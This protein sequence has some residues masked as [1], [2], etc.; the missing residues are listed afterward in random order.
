MEQ[1]LCKCSVHAVILVD[2]KEFIPLDSLDDE[3]E[4]RS[5]PDMYRTIRH[6]VQEHVEDFV[7]RPPGVG[8]GDEA[9]KGGRDKAIHPWACLPT[10]TD[11]FPRNKQPPSSKPLLFDFAG[12]S[13]QLRV[14]Q[15]AT[16]IPRS[17]SIVSST[18]RL[19]TRIIA[20]PVAFSPAAA[21]KPILDLSFYC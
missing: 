19:T 21:M 8:A 16:G 15:K 4:K 5:C 13:Q 2:I 3:E 9:W 11:N 17:P 18:R 1:W 7:G 10:S 6:K 20:S 12:I 14:G